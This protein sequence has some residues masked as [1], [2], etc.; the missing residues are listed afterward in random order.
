MKILALSKS[1]SRHW[2]TGT[3]SG[4]RKSQ[5]DPE[6]HVPGLPGV[7][8]PFTDRDAAIEHLE[9]NGWKVLEVETS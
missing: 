8:T 6:N 2:L 7:F 9:R 5:P 4:G 1:L 3:V